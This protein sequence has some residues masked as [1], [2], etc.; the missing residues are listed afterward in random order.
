MALEIE[1][2]GKMY[3]MLSGYG[4]KPEIQRLLSDMKWV[5][6]RQLDDTSLMV[7]TL[8][9]PTNGYSVFS[10]YGIPVESRREKEG[11]GNTWDQARMVQPTNPADLPDI[12]VLPV[13]EGGFG[14]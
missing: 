9:D 6:Q 3:S 11:S 8:L 4:A 12:G 14:R 2:L 1:T 10:R 13:P 7:Y 5:V